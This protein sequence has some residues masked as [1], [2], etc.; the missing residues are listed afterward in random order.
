M[1]VVAQRPIDDKK[2][3]RYTFPKESGMKKLFLLLCL[4]V[5]SGCSYTKPM[6]VAPMQLGPKEKAVAIGKGESSATYLLGF[7]I[8]GDDS[9]A[10]AVKNAKVKLTIKGTTMANVFVDRHFF[11][12]PACWLPL[13]MESKTSV[14]G[15][16]IAYDTEKEIEK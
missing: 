16:V 13:Y 11:C 6:L 12:F 9:L 5:I 4:L 2:A 7:R 3:K 10:E 8:D 14:F 1:A 15:T